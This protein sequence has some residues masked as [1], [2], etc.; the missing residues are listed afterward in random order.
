MNAT[1]NRKESQIRSQPFTINH[2]VELDASEYAAFC[3]SPLDTY[4]FIDEFKDQSHV[5]EDGIARCIL[6]LCEG[7]DDGVL[8]LSEG[9]EY[10]R[11]SSHLPCAR[12]IAM[13]QRYPSLEK[14]AQD[15][16][17][18]ADRY[19]SVALANQVNGECQIKESSVIE[20]ADID[21]EV[22]ETFNKKLFISMM[23]DRPELESLKWRYGGYTAT[24]TESYL[25]PEAPLRELTQ[26]DVDIMCAKH[27]LWMHDASGGE[28]AN[29][30]GCILKD[31]NLSNRSLMNAVFDGATLSGVKMQSCELCFSTF[32]GARFHNCDMTD[33][34]AEE[35]QFRNAIF[36]GSR[37]EDAIFTHSNF[38]WSKFID[39]NACGANFS[40][41]CMEGVDQNGTQGI[42]L[43]DERISYIEENWLRDA[44]EIKINMEEIE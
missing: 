8:V 21:D 43:G 33:S 4:D 16:A 28:Q 42:D 2:V 17:G 25:K 36:Q 44:N 32:N 13:L 29:F 5:D 37:A 34:V 15:M 12:Q 20:S 9:Y 26:Q 7:Q 3:Q 22:G 39:T 40:H 24:V 6:V 11:Y 14:Y 31:L 1:F 23:N 41:C 38:A 10:A 18:L 19:T 27:T 30:S 35:C